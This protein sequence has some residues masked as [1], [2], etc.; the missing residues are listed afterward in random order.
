VKGLFKMIHEAFP[1]L[2]GTPFLVLAEGDVVT[3]AATWEGT[4]KGKFMGKPAS[5]KKMSWTVVDIIRLVDGKAGRTGM[6]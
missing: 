2:H 1:D 5:N 6:G 3:V 4:N